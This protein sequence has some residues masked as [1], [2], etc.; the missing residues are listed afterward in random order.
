MRLRSQAIRV[1]KYTKIQGPNLQRNY[2]ITGDKTKLFT[3]HVISIIAENKS[4]AHHK[5]HLHT[6]KVYNTRQSQFS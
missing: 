3:W 1:Y 5:T 6:V 4:H 2:I